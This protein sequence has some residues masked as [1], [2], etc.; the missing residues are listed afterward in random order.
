MSDCRGECRTSC[1]DKGPACCMGFVKQARFCVVHLH[2]SLATVRTH[3][4]RSRSP[5]LWPD[6]LSTLT[7]R[8]RRWTFYDTFVRYIGA[9]YRTK[10]A[11]C[12]RPEFES[13]PREGG[14]GGGEGGS[15]TMTSAAENYSPPY[16][17]QMLSEQRAN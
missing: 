8:N 1:G 15:I 10:F 14:K 13:R 5:L 9:H 11:E 7:F 2:R 17:S 4:S 16:A 3:N 6:V 12:N